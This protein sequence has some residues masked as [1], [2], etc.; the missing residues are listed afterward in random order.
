M[1][2]V[3]GTLAGVCRCPVMQPEWLGHLSSEGVSF[4]QAAGQE[5]RKLA[6]HGMTG[7]ED[8]ENP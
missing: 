7:T 2:Q 3:V 8:V 4:L 5:H 1:H 6:R